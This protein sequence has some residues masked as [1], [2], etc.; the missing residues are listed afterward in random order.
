MH[1]LDFNPNRTII[2]HMGDQV[3]VRDEF[4]HIALKKSRSF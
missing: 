2:F 3:R 4:S 1:V